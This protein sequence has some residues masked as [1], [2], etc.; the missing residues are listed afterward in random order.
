MAPTSPLGRLFGRNPFTSLQQHMRVVI[1][2]ADEVPALF[3]ALAREDVQALEA[4]R[5]RIFE[6]EHEADEVRRDLRRNLPRNLFLP[7]NRRDLLE[8]LDSQD[9]IAN[10]A[11]DIAGLLVARRMTIPAA[12]MQP[13]REYVEACVATSHKAASIIEQLDELLET[14]FG[15]REAGQ[16]EEMITDLNITETGTDDLGFA[17]ARLLFEHEDDLKPVS[18]V[19]WYQLIDWIGDLADYGEKT[20][21]LLRLLI[22]R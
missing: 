3:E 2:C 17:L 10:V 19:F 8:V 9:S 11:Q 22:A 18:V 13:L 1:R 4:S 12:M 15:G 16:V 21:N 5:D 6:L 7:V 20:G 14:G